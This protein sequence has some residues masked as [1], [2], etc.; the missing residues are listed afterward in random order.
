MSK[1][2]VMKHMGYHPV[3]DAGCSLLIYNFYNDISIDIYICCKC[4]ISIPLM[5][6]L[7]AIQ[8]CNDFKW[9]S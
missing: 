3:G 1:S 4:V 9:E 7:T 2:N 8:K 5:S 6:A